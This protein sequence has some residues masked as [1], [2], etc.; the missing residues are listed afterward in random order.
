MRQESTAP[1]RCL[2]IAMLVR[3]RWVKSIGLFVG[4]KYGW[5]FHARVVYSQPGALIP[6]SMAPPSG[7]ACQRGGRPVRQPKISGRTLRQCNIAEIITQSGTKCYKRFTRPSWHD[8]KSSQAWLRIE[9]NWQ[10]KTAKATAWSGSIPQ[11][12]GWATD[13]S[14]LLLP[15]W[16]R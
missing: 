7:T 11:A 8:R 15:F 12:S 6:C 2:T 4:C 13:P 14:T 1:Y 5:A 10:R 9:F 3:Q 16:L